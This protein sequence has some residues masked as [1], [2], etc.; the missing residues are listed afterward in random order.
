MLFD[1]QTHTFL[2]DGVLSPMELLRR[3]QH[4]GYTA[5]AITDHASPANLDTLIPAL[6][7]DCQ[8]AEQEWGL[9]AVVG[10]EITHVPPDV[11]DTVAKQAV[12]AG[13]ELI[14]VHGETI[15]E[16]VEA[17]TNRAAIESEHVHMLVHPGLLS[18]ELAQIARKNG[19]TIELSAR[20]GHC[21]TNGH[22]ASVCREAGVP[23][24][25]N[26]DAHEPTDLLSEAL[27]RRVARGAGLNA[28]ETEAAL[29]DNPMELLR[30]LGKTLPDAAVAHG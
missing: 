14:A 12:D 15:A 21:L 25:V 17:G 5:V 26:S 3:C 18:P 22:V 19:I 10:V 1:F 30:R 7:R 27:A 8:I 23:L 13:A 16:P 2:S 28:D 11:I 9:I 20:R 29:V 4:A 6:R 24:V